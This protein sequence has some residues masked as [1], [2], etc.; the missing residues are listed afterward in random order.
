[1]FLYGRFD[2]WVH[3][4]STEV[5]CSS[6]LLFGIQAIKLTPSNEQFIHSSTSLFEVCVCYKYG[7]MCVLRKLF[8]SRFSKVTE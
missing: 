3:L 2:F 4:Q 5:F 8:L 6:D 1:M 7:I